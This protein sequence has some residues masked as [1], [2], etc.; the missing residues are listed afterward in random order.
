MDQALE[1][2]LVLSYFPLFTS[3]AFQPSGSIPIAASSSNALWREGGEPP[4]WS[5][6]EN[7]T[8]VQGSNHNCDVCA[9]AARAGK[10]SLRSTAR[11]WR[12]PPGPRHEQG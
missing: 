4:L 7:S 5:A 6:R 9:W 1:P 8:R 3:G 10:G 2:F 12:D 11:K